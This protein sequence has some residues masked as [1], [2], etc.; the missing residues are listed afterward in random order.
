MLLDLD[1]TL[2]DSRDLIISSVKFAA[3]RAGKR[4]PSVQDIMRQYSVT[5]SPTKIL[6]HFRIHDTEHYW[7]YYSSNTMKLK[8]FDRRIR[9]K[10]NRISRAGVELGLITSLPRDEV[11]AILRHFGLSKC[12]SVVKTFERR[13][14]KWKSIDLAIRELRVNPLRTMYLGD[15]P[16]DVK[17][18]KRADN[19]R[20]IWSGVAY[21]SRKRTQDFSEVEPD[22]IFQKFDE[23]VELVTTRIRPQADCFGPSRRCYTP[24]EHYL[25]ENLKINRQ[26]CRYCFFPSDCPN[27]KRFEKV[28]KLVPN[29]S[30]LGKLSRQVG[31]KVSSCEW[32]YPRNY[33]R[34]MIEDDDSIDT[35]NVLG[36]F[37]NGEHRFR[38]RLGLSMAH[39][40]K[41][42]QDNGA[43]YC[44]I[45]L[46]VPV[47]STK[48]KIQQRGYN[49]PEELAK[50][51]SHLADIPVAIRWLRTTV[52]RSRRMTRYEYDWEADKKRLMKHIHL[53]N[54]PK[55]AGKKILLIDDILT[56][57]VTLSAYA[58]KIGDSVR[59]KP[60]IV[61]LTFGL[62][63]K[64]R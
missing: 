52:K 40:L 56:D 11:N 53:R 63:R 45:D 28:K 16:G 13:A 58:Q 27:C 48:K 24:H 33:P 30:E 50:V 9:K 17:A 26:S 41:K 38:F 2:V 10:L 1:G 39:H 49:P 64:E 21:W 23:V 4:V 14:P 3:R 59:P 47:P 55:L 46:I 19:S 57:G 31:V 25:A 15:M 6:R 12:F 22:F 60:K 37:K 36:A 43:D 18:A 62:T 34:N 54:L 8:L 32:Y 5:T 61:A 35:R 42:L 44:K 29:K 51:L 20:G 7:N